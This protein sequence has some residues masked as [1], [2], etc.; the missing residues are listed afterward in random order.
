MYV[1]S[2]LIE[3]INLIKFSRDYLSFDGASIWQARINRS[4]L[5][6]YPVQL[7]ILYSRQF[8]FI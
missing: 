4:I 5:I 6:I 8:I 7:V 1:G 2:V 3:T